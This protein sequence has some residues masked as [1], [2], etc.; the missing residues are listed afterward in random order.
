MKIVLSKGGVPIRLSE[1]WLAPTVR[2]HP[3]MQSQGIKLL[4]TKE[5][6]SWKKGG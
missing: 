4:E 2:R 1:E 5:T 3:E 6:A